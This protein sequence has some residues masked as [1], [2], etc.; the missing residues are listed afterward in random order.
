[1]L[2][3]EG[4]ADV[5]KFWRYQ[6]KFT[7]AQSVLDAQDVL[8]VKFYVTNEYIL[9]NMDNRCAA[10]HVS[11]GIFLFIKEVPYEIYHET[12]YLVFKDEEGVIYQTT[13]DSSCY[14]CI[15]SLFDAY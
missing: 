3:M 10:C 12:S 14:T 11:D 5:V 13:Q 15:V 9:R 2:W 8:H 6:E 7:I 4:S 1:M